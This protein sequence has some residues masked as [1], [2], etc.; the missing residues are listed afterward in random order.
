M[1]GGIFLGKLRLWR[2]SLGGACVFSGI[3]MAHFGAVVDSEMLVF[4]QNF[5]LVLFVY[6]LGVQVGPGFVASFRK[7]GF[8]LNLWGMHS[9]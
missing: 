5:G 7:R 3:L 9:S 6:A 2:F 1:R 8:K 4:A